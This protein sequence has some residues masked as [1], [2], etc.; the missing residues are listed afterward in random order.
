MSRENVELVRSIYDRWAEGDFRAGREL[1]DPHITTVWAE[2]FP[3]AG[4]YHGPDGHAAAM[5]EWLS[6]WTE[7][8]LEAERFVDAGDSVVVPFVVR[9]RGLE[10]G[11]EV[12]R[13]WA[14]VWTLHDGRVVRFEVHLDV[15]EA[16]RAVDPRESA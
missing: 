10:S 16:L 4:T 7:F 2:E 9:A 15:A 14:H 1:L 8:R 12:E 5:R 6:A 3:T 11:V 13:R